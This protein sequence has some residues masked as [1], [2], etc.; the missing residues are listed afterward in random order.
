MKGLDIFIIRFLPFILF[1]IYGLN[2]YFAC[3]DREPFLSYELHGNSAL[4]SLALFFISLANKR[5][6]CI[7]NRAM[8]VFL[9]AIPL[10]NYLDDK[11]YLVQTEEAYIITLQVTYGLTALITAYLAIRHFVQIS[12]RRMERGRE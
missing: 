2:V 9:I 11:F 5:Y 4:Y 1:I 8:Y 3:T 12:K 6:H 10:F 7:W